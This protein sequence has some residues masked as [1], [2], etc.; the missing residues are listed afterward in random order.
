MYAIDLR[1]VR[2]LSKW[3]FKRNGGTLNGGVKST[4]LLSKARSIK[5]YR[6]NNNDDDDGRKRECEK[7]D[8]AAVLMAVLFFY[9]SLT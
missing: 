1:F 3:E 5:Q 7:N 6:I 9:S 4:R 2:I 8:L